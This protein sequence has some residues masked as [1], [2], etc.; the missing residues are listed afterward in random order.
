M[1]NNWVMTILFINFSIVSI[2]LW[3]VTGL[4]CYIN[5]NTN[6]KIKNTI[7]ECGFITIS[8]NIFPI[9][10]NT[11]LL[12]LFVIIY[13]IEFILMTPL[14]I[15][16]YTSGISTKLVTLIFFYVII[17]TLLI[18]INLRKVTWVF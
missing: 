6:H 8:K 4:E 3:L 2:I 1:L 10:L 13:E 16:M 7:Y 14:L 5:K 12:L 18:D 15:T 9:S 11:I 17:L